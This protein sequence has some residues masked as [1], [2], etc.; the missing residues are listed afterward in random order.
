[1]EWHVESAC[2]KELE[3]CG[4]SIAEFEF[5]VT[6]GGRD[7]IFRTNSENWENEGLLIV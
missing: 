6:S 1:M 2:I 7:V 4:D 5:D 3:K